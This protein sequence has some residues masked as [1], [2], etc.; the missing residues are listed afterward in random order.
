MGNQKLRRRM[1]GEKQ[2]DEPKNQTFREADSRSTRHTTSFTMCVFVCVWVW[3]RANKPL[4]PIASRQ[5]RSYVPTTLQLDS[6]FL[7]FLFFSFTF[8]L[9]FF[10]TTI[11]DCSETCVRV[12]FICCST[13]PFSFYSLSLFCLRLNCIRCYCWWCCCCSSSSSYSSIVV[14]F[15]AV[16]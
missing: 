13:L 1:N 4:R 3:E 15:F 14:F 6:W 10:L 9:S 2:H 11:D 16:Y 5:R 8:L 12:C 7:L